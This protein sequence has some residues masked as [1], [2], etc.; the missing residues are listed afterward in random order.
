MKK[1][2]FAILAICLS[3]SYAH[4]ECL[5]V[6]KILYYVIEEEQWVE[7]EMERREEYTYTSEWMDGYYF[8]LY[9]AYGDVREYIE[10][11]DRKGRLCDYYEEALRLPYDY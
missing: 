6:P 5:T 2:I 7:D 8:G 9:V 1:R 11:S 4:A 3:C 10:M